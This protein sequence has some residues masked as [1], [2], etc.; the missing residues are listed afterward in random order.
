LELGHVLDP[1]ARHH[2]DVEP[3]ILRLHELDEP[4]RLGVPAAADLPGGPGHVVPLRERRGR[5]EAEQQ[6]E[7][8]PSPHHDPPGMSAVAAPG[9]GSLPAPPPMWRSTTSPSGRPLSAPG[10][11]RVAR[12]PWRVPAAGHAGSSGRLACTSRTRSTASNTG[13]PVADWTSAR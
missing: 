2:A 3:G 6:C 8:E 10:T 13:S 4:S 9:A 1:G 7:S 12:S 5:A 11:A